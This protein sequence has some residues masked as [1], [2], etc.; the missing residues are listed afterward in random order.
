M[1][2][3]KKS[4]V[5]DISKFILRKKLPEFAGVSEEKANDVVNFFWDYL[6]MEFAVGLGLV[7]LSK[8]EEAE[9]EDLHFFDQVEEMFDK[10]KSQGGCY[11]C[12]PY[13]DPNDKVFDPMTTKVCLGCSLRLSNFVQALGIDP[14]KVFK[15]AKLNPEQPRIYPRLW[16]EE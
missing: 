14:T 6:K 5:I 11:F 15:L 1:T 16:G 7:N 3:E 8:E 10:A 2:D 12:D 9:L 13:L 4:N